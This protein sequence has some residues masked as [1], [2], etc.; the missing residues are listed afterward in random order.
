MPWARRRQWASADLQ[1]IARAQAD[2]RVEA[3]CTGGAESFRGASARAVGGGA[4]DV[5]IARA[6]V[7]TPVCC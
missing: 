3:H 1:G 6:L 7:T 2:S 4:V 5:P